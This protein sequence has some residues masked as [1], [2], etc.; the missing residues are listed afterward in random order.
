MYFVYK[1]TNLIDGKVYIGVT[2]QNPPS[3][4]WR[5]GKG[6]KYNLHF[7]RAI[8]KYTWAGFNHEILFENLTKSQAE[9]KERELIKFYNSTNEK[10]GYNLESGGNLSKK[11]SPETRKKLSEAHKGQVPWI[12]GKKHTEEARKK[13]HEANL[14]RKPISEE[15]KKKKSEASKGEKNGF[16]GRRHTEESRRK[17]SQSLKGR[18]VWNKGVPMKENVRRKASRIVLQYDKNGNF[19]AKFFGTNEAKRRTGICHI[20][21]CARGGRKT[22]GGYVWKYEEDS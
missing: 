15:T 22:A 1:H 19:I 2:N 20:D 13:I 14:R 11:L 12:A 18:K 9:E 3:R 8:E 7:Y 17:M 5:N 4:R 6:Y 16:Y 21:L 10:F